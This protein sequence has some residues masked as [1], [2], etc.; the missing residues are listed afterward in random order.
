MHPTPA[1]CGYPTR[2]ARKLINLI[3]PFERGMFG[4]LVGWCD[5]EGNGEW[6]V[7]IRCGRMAGSRIELFAGAGIVAESRPES[8][9]D[10][11]QAKL[12]TMVNALGLAMP[13]LDA[14]GEYRAQAA[15]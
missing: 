3:E 6:A 13:A 2:M 8:E 5:A 12:Q 1:L 14:A 7:T 4:G 10:E 9:W 11:T 15:A